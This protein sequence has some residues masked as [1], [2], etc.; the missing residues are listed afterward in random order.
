[1]LAKFPPNS[2]QHCETG[3]TILRRN[4]PITLYGSQAQI[5]PKF[6]ALPGT[7]S[8]RV[9][10][11]LEDNEV[12]SQRAV[13]M[14][15]HMLANLSGSIA[16]EIR[17]PLAAINHAAQLLDESEEI[18]EAD[19][20]LVDIIHSQSGR[21]NG[22]V[23]NILQLSRHEKSRPDIFELV[24]FL[25]EISVETKSSLPGIRL[26]LEIEP[27]DKERL[28]YLTAASYTRPFGNYWKMPTTCPP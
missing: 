9:L 16:H 20:R 23:E 15:A 13:E 19:L 1:M 7:S 3:M 22:I 2:I 25:E 8:I 27:E 26:T 10:I 14:S 17:N 18:A 11:F 12:I 21:M 6:V 24:P 5:I 4:C 28:F